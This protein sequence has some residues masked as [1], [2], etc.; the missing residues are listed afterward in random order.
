MER[1]P[2]S[3]PASV[4]TLMRTYVVIRVIQKPVVRSVTSICPR[5]NKT[6]APEPGS[7]G[8]DVM[9][10]SASVTGA[11]STAA[12]SDSGNNVSERKKRRERRIGFTDHSSTRGNAGNTA[13]RV[14]AKYE[15]IFTTEISDLE[16][17]SRILMLLRPLT[18]EIC[19]QSSPHRDCWVA[20]ARFLLRLT[21]LGCCRAIDFSDTAPTFPRQ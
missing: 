5:L 9:A 13:P 6:I 12:V 8:F 11:Q 7:S 19:D 10:F 17:C 15:K 2:T 4:S 1:L 20:T 18:Q 16:S 14:I 3:R 21:R